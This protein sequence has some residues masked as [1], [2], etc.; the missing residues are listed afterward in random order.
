MKYLKY[1]IGALWGS[2]ET[3]FMIA[4]WNH[5]SGDWGILV[6]LLGLFVFLANIIY[7]INFDML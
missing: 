5:F 6:V 3:V 2:W 1:L 7:W 4:V